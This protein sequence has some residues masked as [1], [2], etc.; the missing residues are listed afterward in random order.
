MSFF[1]LT[2]LHLVN[3][4]LLKSKEKRVGVHWLLFINVK[5]DKNEAIQLNDVCE[6]L[7]SVYEVHS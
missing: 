6:F 7:F 5:E 2:L 1:M 3:L 4:K